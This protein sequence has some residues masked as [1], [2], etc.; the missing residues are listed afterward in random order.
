MSR[1]HGPLLIV[2][3]H[4]FAGMQRGPRTTIISSAQLESYSKVVN[5]SLPMTGL[6]FPYT[7]VRVFHTWKCARTQPDQEWDAL[8][9]VIM[10]SDVDWDPAIMD[11]EFP[12]SGQENDLDSCVYDNNTI[13]D[14]RGQYK[15]RALVASARQ[16]HHAPV[17]LF[18]SDPNPSHPV[19]A[20][21]DWLCTS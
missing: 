10:T 14:A 11:G 21:V 6:S 15:N 9:H 3:F 19:A 2:V 13:F 7:F 18:D 1:N 17:H 5:S 20:P 8:P 12:L 4:Q 16:H